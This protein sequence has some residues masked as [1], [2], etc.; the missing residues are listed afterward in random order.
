MP[1]AFKCFK[2]IPELIFFSLTKNVTLFQIEELIKENSNVYD[3]YNLNTK[4]F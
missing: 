2:I 4:T 1:W 3:M